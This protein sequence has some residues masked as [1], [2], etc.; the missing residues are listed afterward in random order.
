MPRVLTLYC[1]RIRFHFFAASVQVGKSC[2]T[3]AGVEDAVILSVFI[4]RCGSLVD[5]FED[6]TAGESPVF[7]M[8]Q[9][10]ISIQLMGFGEMLGKV[11]CVST[12]LL[13]SLD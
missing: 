2:L 6:L 12:P 8:M 1:Y 3:A 5:C 7:L 9:D 10:N 13:W 11:S 4:S